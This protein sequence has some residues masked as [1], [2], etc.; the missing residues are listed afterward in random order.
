[1]STTTF[2]RSAVLRALDAVAERLID[3][4]IHAPDLGL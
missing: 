3:L 1:M 2:E 4:V